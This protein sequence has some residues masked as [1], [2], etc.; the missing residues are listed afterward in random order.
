MNE[1]RGMQ[2]W[3]AEIERQ[4]QVKQD[5]IVPTTDL[6]MTPDSAVSFVSN[7]QSF[8][9]TPNFHGQLAGRLKIPKAYYDRVKE[10]NPPLLAD[11]VNHWL[12]Q[13]PEKRMVRVM[14]GL[15]RAYLSDS[16]R[17]LDN[18][19]LLQSILPTLRE[20]DFKIKSSEILYNRM[21]LKVTFPE[22][23]AEITHSKRVGD[24]VEGGL[25]ISN[26]E[27]GQGSLKIEPFMY[28]LAC[29]NGMVQNSLV[30]KYHVGRRYDS[31]MEY[32]EL[33]TDATNKAINDAF[34][35]KV[36]DLVKG[37]IDV[38][39]FKIRVEH[40]ETTTQN[41]IE[42]EPEQVVEIVKRNYALSDT[43]GAEIFTNLMNGD[44]LSQFGLANAV[45][46]AGNIQN[47][48]EESNKLETIGGDIIDL[49]RDQWE[50]LA[51]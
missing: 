45:T 3:A 18:K 4:A 23:R 51:A 32:R 43:Q 11:N 40:L 12:T 36:Q 38:D 21:Y 20:H 6:V 29:T 1:G 8:K 25:V 39:L 35:M 30:R 33:I 41:G 48:Y 22:M 46:A 10:S 27:I 16:Y 17:I 15:A 5:F 42:K 14:D 37:A 2:A 31:D 19:D 34:W 13:V 47:L 50:N 9:G 24:F 28:F 49:P 44:D 7:Q 26:S